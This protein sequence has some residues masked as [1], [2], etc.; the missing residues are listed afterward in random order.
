LALLLPKLWGYPIAALCSFL[1]AKKIADDWLG[2]NSELSGV[3]S[4]DGSVSYEKMVEHIRMVS[5]E[6]TTETYISDS[7]FLGL[8]L[9]LFLYSS[10]SL[11]SSITKRSPFAP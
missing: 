2:W 6:Y 9:T 1:V 4:G 8:A 5:V 11:L 3:V 10:I 7:L